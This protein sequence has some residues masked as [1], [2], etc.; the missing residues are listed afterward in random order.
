M[1]Q[2]LISRWRVKQRGRASIHVILG[3]SEFLFRSLAPAND[4][5]RQI[6]HNDAM[7]NLLEHEGSF[8]QRRRRETCPTA[9]ANSLEQ[10]HGF[11]VRGDAKL[12]AETASEPVKM[13]D[14]PRR[15]SLS[16]IQQH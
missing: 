13:T 2:R 11:L 14:C 15:A 7:G 4:L 16:N 1:G 3:E 12:L 6:G 8:N 5:V 9:G 10:R